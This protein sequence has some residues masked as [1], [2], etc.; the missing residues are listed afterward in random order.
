M[1]GYFGADSIAAQLEYASRL[2]LV[3]TGPPQCLR[4]ETL[5]EVVE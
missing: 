3:A 4:D 2:S 1:L 5:L